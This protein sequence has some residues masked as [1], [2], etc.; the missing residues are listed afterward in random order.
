[1]E[2]VCPSLDYHRLDSNII[3]HPQFQCAAQFHELDVRRATM[4]ALTQRIGL[5]AVWI[6]WTGVVFGHVAQLVEGVS[7]QFG[8]AGAVDCLW[9]W[10]HRMGVFCVVWRG[11]ACGV[12]QQRGI[13]FGDMG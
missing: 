13:G 8:T 6:L 1:M 4:A 3:F 11:G 10:I 5:A 12:G 2:S 7:R 9:R